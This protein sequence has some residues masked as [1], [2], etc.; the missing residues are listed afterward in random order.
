M[1]PLKPISYHY[2]SSDLLISSITVVPAT[3]VPLLNLSPTLN[4][5]LFLFYSSTTA[6]ATIG[7]TLI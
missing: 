5:F 7:I 1:K 2:T 6:A 3:N 4:K